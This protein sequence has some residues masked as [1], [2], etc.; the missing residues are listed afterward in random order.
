MGG[1]TSPRLENVEIPARPRALPVR[2]LDADRYPALIRRLLVDPTV[3]LGDRVAGV[4]VL[5][6]GQTGTDIVRLT[7]DHVERRDDGVLLRLGDDPC[8]LHGSVACLLVELIDSKRRGSAAV[9]APA[10]QRWLFP[11]SYAGRHLT[12]AH[13]QRR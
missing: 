4:L 7:V 10:G 1:P 5:L 12:P 3:D 11:G 6:Y 13:I 2:P 9:G 8:V